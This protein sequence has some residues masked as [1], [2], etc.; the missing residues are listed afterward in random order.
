M[1]LLL[2]YMG[3]C[4]AA[5]TAAIVIKLIAT[6]TE[7]VL[8]YILE[9]IIDD[10]VPM[11]SLSLVLLVMLPVLI[12]IVFFVSSRGIPLYQ[13]VQNSLAPWS[14]SCV[15]TSAESVLSN[16]SARARGR[17]KDLQPPMKP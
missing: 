4:K 16:L 9:Y 10:I 5:I 13:T 17:K 12:C 11:G 14:V 15:K 7:L 2:R 8:P 3:H 6:M 1:K